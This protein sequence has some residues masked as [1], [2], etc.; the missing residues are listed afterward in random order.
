VAGA[1]TD[2]YTY[3]AFGNLLARTGATPNEYLYA[4]ERF[5][6][7]LGLYRLRARY[8]NPA[9]GRFQTMDS[10]EGEQSDP[11]SL[12][13]YLYAGDDPVNNIDPSGHSYLALAGGTLAGGSLQGMS[14]LNYAVTIALIWYLLAAFVQTEPY[15]RPETETATTPDPEPEPETKPKQTTDRIPPAPRVKPDDDEDDKDKSEVFYR[16]MSS[17]EYAKVR[18]AQGRLSLK[19]DTRELFVTQSLNYVATL[20]MRDSR[21][22]VIVKYNMILGTR[23]AL[24]SRGAIDSSIQEKVPALRHLPHVEQHNPDQ[25]HLKYE[26]G[27]LTFGLRKNTIGIFNGGIKS[28]R[29]IGLNGNLF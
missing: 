27:A 11:A 2:T 19:S 1:V 4:G 26:R 3:D 8:M 13:K 20:S 7:H 9:T 23:E 17:G 18:A 14:V 5:D 10:F 25:V 29:Q 16:A 22:P 21:F 15:V 6:P 12:H 28:F 24:I